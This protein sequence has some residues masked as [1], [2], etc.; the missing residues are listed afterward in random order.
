MRSFRRASNN[1]DVNII[2]LI[3]ES[4]LRVI[5]SIARAIEIIADLIASFNRIKRHNTL[6]NRF[7][8][9]YHS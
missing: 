1:D 8:V 7:R 2:K 5:S 3:M 6:R 4:T 9:E